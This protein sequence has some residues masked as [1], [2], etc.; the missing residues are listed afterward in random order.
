M[1]STDPFLPS[2]ESDKSPT[3][4]LLGEVGILVMRV[5]TAVLLLHHGQDKLLHA[6]AFSQGT[7]GAFFGFLPGPPEFWTYAAASVEIVGSVCLLLG[8]F[9]RAA[10]ALLCPTMLFALSWH[11]RKFGLQNFP[12]DPAKGGA[13]TFEPC[14]A[15]FGVTLYFALNGPGRIALKPRGL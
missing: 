1:A 10:A 8:L 15:F 13:Y 3:S 2:A 7:V 11:L 9:A 14:L 6:D 12:L 5:I 4:A